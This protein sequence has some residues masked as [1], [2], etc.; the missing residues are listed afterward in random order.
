MSE[1][2]VKNN[3]SKFDGGL[4]QWI[5]WKIVGFFVTII[6]CGIC[7]PW[8]ICM[9]YRW[10]I[11]HTVIEGKRLRFD[12]K[13][14]GL[15]GTW[16]KCLLLTIITIGIYGFWIP[17]KIEKWKVKHTFFVTDE[18]DFV[19]NEN[20]KE[21]C[22]EAN[23]KNGN[24]EVAETTLSENSVNVNKFLSFI[25]LFGVLIC[26]LEPVISILRE[27]FHVSW[28]VQNFRYAFYSRQGLDIFY[29]IIN[30]IGKIGCILGFVGTVICLVNYIKNKD[31][32]SMLML[33]LIGF[34]FYVILSV[35]V[36]FSGLFYYGSLFVEI[37]RYIII[38]VGVIL[39]IVFANKQNSFVKV[40][41]KDNLIP[42]ITLFTT[43]ICTLIPVV[44][45][46]R[47]L[48]YIK[49]TF[50]RIR[51]AFLDYNISMGV[52]TILNLLLGLCCIAGFIG[53]IMCLVSF[54]QRK[55]IKSLINFPLVCFIAY[56][57]LDT[58]VAIGTHRI[59]YTKANYGTVFS[60]IGPIIYQ[61]LLLVSIIITKIFCVKH[62][63]K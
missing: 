2:L 54:S 22:Q 19:G 57:V 40:S 42:F 27:L 49:W 17:I 32:K 55:S 13:A 28:I 6:T 4:L 53:S 59:G 16:I 36:R 43:L 34:I 38:I 29:I 20:N 62:S 30:Y 11:K 3:D 14:I 8:A 41:K 52:Y 61:I 33:P 7:Y 5:G 58:I 56:T 47:N 44:E 24:G 15:F 45:N 1:E 51:D 25:G 12:G 10:R 63:E 9:I 31:T 37:L 39:A 46:L 48:L 60:L 50:Y 18:N 21:I 23:G 26:T 35:V